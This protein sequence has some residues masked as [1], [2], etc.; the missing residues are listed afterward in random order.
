MADTLP[1]TRTPASPEV[2]EAIRAADLVVIGPGDLFTSIIPNLLVSGISDAINKSKAE[3]VFVMNLMTKYGQ[4]TGFTASDH[5][6][7]LEKY[8]EDSGLELPEPSEEEKEAMEQA[9]KS[10]E[11]ETDEDDGTAGEVIEEQNKVERGESENPP[12][13]FGIFLEKR[14]A[15]YYTFES[16]PSDGWADPEVHKDPPNKREEALRFGT[17]ILLWALSN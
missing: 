5:L 7:D 11:E 1:L 9:E 15:V 10:S 17:N 6:A 16:N 13:G 4:T 14:L 2:A 8:I 3:V 12:Q